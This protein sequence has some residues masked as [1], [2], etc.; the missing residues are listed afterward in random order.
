LAGVLPEIR[1]QRGKTSG[2]DFGIGTTVVAGRADKIGGLGLRVFISNAIS[3]DLACSCG[4]G[5]FNLPRQLKEHNDRLY[6][7]V[8]IRRR[9]FPERLKRN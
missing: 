9:G 8:M 5:T 6:R 7:S 3:T 4:L 2:F 1:Q